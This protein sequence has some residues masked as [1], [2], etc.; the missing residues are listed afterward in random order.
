[1]MVKDKKVERVKRFYVEYDKIDEDSI[2]KLEITGALLCAS[3]TIILLVLIRTNS[4]LEVV[5]KLTAIIISSIIVFNI[6][7]LIV[8]FFN[9]VFAKRYIK[10]KR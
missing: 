5:G 1:M 2:A 6:P 9:F 7:A 10:I 4:F 3:S 8:K